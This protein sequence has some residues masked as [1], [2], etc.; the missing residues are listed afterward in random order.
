MKTRRRKGSSKQKGGGG[1]WQFL[2]E[3]PGEIPKQAQLFLRSWQKGHTITTIPSIGNWIH[4]YGV[5][6]QSRFVPLNRIILWHP[7]RGA[8]ERE[9]AG[10][11]TSARTQ[12]M[13]DYFRSLNNESQNTEIRLTEKVFSSIPTMKSSDPISA[14]QVTPILEGVYQ[15]VKTSA[16]TNKNK[17]RDRTRIRDLKTQM[18]MKQLDLERTLEGPRKYASSQTI[19]KDMPVYNSEGPYFLVSSGQGRLQG[20]KEAVAEL[21]L[22]ASRIFIELFVYDVPRNLCNLFIIVGNEFRED[23][24]FDDARHRTDKLWLPTALSCTK[25]TL[26]GTNILSLLDEVSYTN[27]DPKKYFN[28][29]PINPKISNVDPSKGTSGR[30]WLGRF[31]RLGGLF[32][33]EIENDDSIDLTKSFDAANSIESTE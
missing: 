23:G 24:F 27:A 16:L 18:N 12:S 4:S 21:G 14:I 26:H 33:Y 7:V 10:A 30:R 3:K 29:R 22:D 17:R 8:S 25:D 15:N 13:I 5:N 11:K 2:I 9:Q 31:G 1:F 19:P 28:E 20:I 6:P 32:G